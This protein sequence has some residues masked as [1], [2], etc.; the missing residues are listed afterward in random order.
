M[1][2]FVTERKRREKFQDGASMR[3]SKICCSLD[4]LAVTIDEG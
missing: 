3:F 1:R 4:T 2:R